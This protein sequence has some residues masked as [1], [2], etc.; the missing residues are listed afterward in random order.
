[1]AISLKARLRSLGTK[2]KVF[3]HHSAMVVK[4]TRVLCPTHQSAPMMRFGS[5]QRGKQGEYGNRSLTD[6]TIA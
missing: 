2:P 5:R 3:S 4:L 6:R 1:M